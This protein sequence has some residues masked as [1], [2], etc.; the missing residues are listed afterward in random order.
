[1]WSWHGPRPRRRAG[2]L[3]SVPGVGAVTALAFAAT[4]ETRDPVCQVARAGRLSG[5]DGAALSVRGDGLFGADIEERRRHAAQPALRGGQLL[6]PKV[7]NIDS[8]RRHPPCLETGIF[9][10]RFSAQVRGMG[11]AW[12]GV[13]VRGAASRGRR[14]QAWGAARPVHKP[15]STSPRPQAPVHKIG[16][17][18][19][20]GRLGGPSGPG[21]GQGAG[22]GAACVGKPCR[23]L[24]LGAPASPAAPLLP[25]HFGPADRPGG[26]YGSILSTFGI[27]HVLD[28][29]D[30]RR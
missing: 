20:S 12:R 5:A 2:L 6:I 1:M 11:S 27:V 26:L 14:P 21:A 7:L 16:G 17:R 4:I 30:L 24:G 10:Q 18:R 25:A 28:R 19:R 29:L 15:P 9:G 23:H 22:Q 13:A 3:M 8:V